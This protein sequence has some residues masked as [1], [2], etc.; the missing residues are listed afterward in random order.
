MGYLMS[1]IKSIKIIL[2]LA[3]SLSANAQVSQR[4]PTAP[5]DQPMVITDSIYFR[6]LFTFIQ[7]L[8]RRARTTYP[9]VK[10]MYLQGLPAGNVFFVTTGLHD[11]LNHYEQVFVEVK[12]ISN[13]VIHGIIA[14][15][16]GAVIGYK[17]GDEYS[18]PETIIL[19]WTISKPDG[20]EQGNLIGKFF[21][22]IQQRQ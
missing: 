18:L 6:D 8:I 17:L 15:E 3:T 11:S 19:D 4:A 20:S 14:S 22:K 9:T 16:I 10:E 1:T 2:M 7:P 13:G 21:D 5:Q 12:S